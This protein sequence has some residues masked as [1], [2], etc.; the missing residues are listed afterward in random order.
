M[1]KIAL[2]SSPILLN[3]KAKC[4]QTDL[5]R[6][7]MTLGSHFHCVPFGNQRVCPYTRQP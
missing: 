4:S 5:H 7:I 3:T 2:V 1:E 6:I